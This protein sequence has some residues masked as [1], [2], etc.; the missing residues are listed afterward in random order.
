MDVGKLAR[1]LAMNRI[2]F[3]AGLI[4]LSRLYARTWIGADGA[5]DDRAKLLARALGARDLALGTGGLLALRAGDTER[6]KQ[7]FA[8]QGA[9]DAV[10]FVA[11]LAAGDRVPTPARVFAATVAAGSA[12]IAAAYVAQAGR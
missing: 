5:A 9:S 7:W 3:G 4:L 1:G 11:T 12:A 8:A 6:A 10:D 2:S